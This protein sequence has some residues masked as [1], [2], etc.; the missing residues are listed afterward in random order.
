MRK[1]RSKTRSR[2]ST[3]PTWCAI[4]NWGYLESK[5]NNGCAKARLPRDRTCKACCLGSVLS[6][7]RIFKEASSG[8]LRG[9]RFQKGSVSVLARRH[10]FL[11]FNS[12]QANRRLADVLDGV[13]FRFFPKNLRRFSLFRIRSGRKTDFSDSPVG[14]CQPRCSSLQYDNHTLD[15]FVERFELPGFHT[16]LQDTDPIVFKDEFVELWSHHQGVEWIKLFRFLQEKTSGSD[17]QK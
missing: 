10:A 7:C 1:V 11:H 14:K 12:N 4:K 15:V 9:F 17:S 13:R 8:I 16:H 6:V 2:T 5:S 3:G